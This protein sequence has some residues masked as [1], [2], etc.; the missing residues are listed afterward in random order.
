M[1]ETEIGLIE[2]VTI[3]K[4]GVTLACFHSEGNVDIN[5]DIM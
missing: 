4:I 5:K 1:D 3:F 2:F